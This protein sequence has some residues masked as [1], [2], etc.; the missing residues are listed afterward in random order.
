VTL[1]ARPTRGS[2]FAGWA[3]A[4]HG[5]AARCTVE[6]TRATAVRARFV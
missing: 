3:G 4:C 1:T 2:R 6:T 5:R